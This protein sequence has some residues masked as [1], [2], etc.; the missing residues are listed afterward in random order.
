MQEPEL[1]DVRS[2]NLLR[3]RFVIYAL[4]C[5]LGLPLAAA[6]EEDISQILAEAEAFL[7]QNTL[8]LTLE[9]LREA[10]RLAPDDY[11]VHKVRGDVQMSFRRNQEALAAYRQAITISPDALDAHW[12]L[13]SLLDR[14]GAHREALLSLKEIVRVDSNNPLAHLRFARALSQAD[15]L[16]EAVSSYRRAVELDPDN[17]SVRL[18]F[19]RALY[20]VLEYAA[21]RQQLNMVLA[22]AD[23]G[24]P[25]WASAHDL[26]SHLRGESYDKGRRFDQS[27]TLRK[28]RWYSEQNLK[29]SVLARGKG[30]QWMEQ[31]RHADAEA[32]FRKALSFNPEDH[33]AMYDLGLVLVEQSRYEEAIESFEKG[34]R[35]TKFAEFYPD[36]VFQIGRCLAKLG[37]WKEAVARFERVLEI[38]DWQNEDFYALNFPNLAKVQK[39]LDEAR[40]HLPK[41]EAVANRER[42]PLRERYGPEPY[43]YPIPPLQNGHKLIDPIPAMPQFTPIGT[44]TVQGPFRQLMTARDVIQDDLQTGLHEFMPL[45]PTD[46]FSQEDAEIFLVF[47]LTSTQEDELR[48][49]SRLIAERSKEFPPNTLIG[50][51]KVQLG[52][53]ERSGYFVL[54]RPEGGWKSGTYRVDLY[55]GDRVSAY[56]HMADVWFRIVYKE[57]MIHE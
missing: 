25:E 48:L 20:D 12:A 10:A 51:D 18:Q 49:S 52:L 21:A 11:R 19:A 33:R 45:G 31:G 23:I 9:R 53:N 8:Y 14:M 1:T 47:T 13:W 22:R 37:R 56:T 46:T 44:E 4:L 5:L 42:P 6:A 43:E 26:L 34:I 35:L 24:S 28:L 27:Q 54:R 41:A 2:R 17:L 29:E 30:W 3:Q 55:L 15:R 57:R 50:S 16:E 7:H 36:S 40:Q 39:A 38:R 32:A